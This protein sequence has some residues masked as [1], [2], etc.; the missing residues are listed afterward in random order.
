LPAIEYTGNIYC[1]PIGFKGDG[2]AP[3]KSKHTET[4]IKV[5]S[6]RSTHWECAEAFAL[7]EDSVHVTGGN[8]WRSS[9]GYLRKERRQLS[10]GSRGI[11]HASHYPAFRAAL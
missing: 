5:I 10:L 2:Y 3:A 6:R 4:R 8:L 11:K 7:F 1:L 9:E